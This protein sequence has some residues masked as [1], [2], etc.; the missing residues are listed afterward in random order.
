V[1]RSAHLLGVLSGSDS[2]DGLE[3]VEKGRST[4]SLG[5]A[6][7][8]AVAAVRVGQLGKAVMDGNQKAAWSA[9]DCGK[10]EEQKRMPTQPKDHSECVCCE[11][12]EPQK[13]SGESR[14]GPTSRKGIGRGKRDE[15]AI[16]RT[17]E[18]EERASDEPLFRLQPWCRT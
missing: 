15:L 8:V 12:E 9:S 5:S 2:G 6:R 11:R 10:R 13:R 3:N 4:P 7:V 1:S 17:G 16:N 14:W 18:R